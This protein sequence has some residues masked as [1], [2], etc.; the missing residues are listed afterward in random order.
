VDLGGLVGGLGGDG[1][2]SL[3]SVGTVSGRSLDQ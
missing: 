3:M 1:R 2:D